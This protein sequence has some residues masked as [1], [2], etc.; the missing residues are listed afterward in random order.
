M[1]H[2]TTLTPAVLL[3]AAS[4]QRTQQ[5]EPEPQRTD[6]EALSTD[7]SA[8]RDTLAVETAEKAAEADKAA[9]Q[10]TLPTQT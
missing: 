5:A 2:L 10:Q 3:P 1:R 4:C 9:M 8:T 6:A 7:T